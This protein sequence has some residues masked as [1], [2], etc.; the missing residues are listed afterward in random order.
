VLVAAQG[1]HALQLWQVGDGQAHCL[2]TLALPAPV[3]VY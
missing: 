2:S 3:G 1:E